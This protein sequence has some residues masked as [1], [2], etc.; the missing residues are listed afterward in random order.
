M[1]HRI[2]AC[3]HQRRGVT[4]D[5]DMR[6]QSELNYILTKQFTSLNLSFT[7]SEIV[8]CENAK[9]LAKFMLG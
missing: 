6:A 4:G 2:G 1:S 9:T 7:R 8:V 3:M 5:R